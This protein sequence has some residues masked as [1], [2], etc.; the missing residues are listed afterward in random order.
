MKQSYIITIESDIGGNIKGTKL[1][2][3]IIEKYIK[4]FKISY[5]F[6]PNE[7]ETKINFPANGIDIFYEFVYTN[8][9]KLSK[10]IKTENKIPIFL[11]G[12]HSCSVLSILSIQGALK[13][14]QNKIG[15]IW[16]D[17]HA[18]IHSPYTTPSGNLHGMPLAIICKEDNLQNKKNEISKNIQIYW[19]NFKKLSKN[20]IDFKNIIY[21][22]IRDFE[23]EEKIII[24]KNKI[25]CV[26][27]KIFNNFNTKFIKKEIIE[28]LKDCR[29][30]HISFDIDSLD[31]KYIKSV[32][33]PVKNGIKIK[34]IIELIK[35]LKK[36]QKRL[37]IEICEFNPIL[38]KENKDIKKIAIILNK[39]LQIIEQK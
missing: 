18:D 29:Y 16:I 28:Y 23:E 20:K 1:F 15:I 19:E 27:P 8:I 17:A 26:E 25:K 37:S 13:D 6:I 12:D 14:T 30:I 34:K 36:T 21:I 3:R 31:P 2:P 7:K 22:G 38:D 33:T 24:K 9:N 39:I 11:N 10:I 4:D 35:N 5:K 32:G